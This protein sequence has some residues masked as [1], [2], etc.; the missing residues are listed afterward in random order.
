MKKETPT[1][2]YFCEFF[3]IIKNSFFYRT[4][5]VAAP[6]FIDI[7]LNTPLQKQPPEVFYEKPFLKVNKNLIIL[8]TKKLSHS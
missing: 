5:P 6:V 8:Q 7:V 2:A 4:S 3:K 1:Q